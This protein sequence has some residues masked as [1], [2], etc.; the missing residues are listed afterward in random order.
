MRGCCTLF[1]N[2]PIDPIAPE[3][4]DGAQPFKRSHLRLM[5]H[6]RVPRCLRHT[7]VALLLV[8]ANL[9]HA[10]LYGATKETCL[11]LSTRARGRSTL[12]E[13]SKKNRTWGRKFANE[14]VRGGGL[15]FITRT[16]L[17]LGAPGSAVFCKEMSPTLQFQPS[18]VKLSPNILV[19]IKQ[20]CPPTKARNA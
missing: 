12:H 18:G 16:L 7:N 20:V 11:R 4:P 1:I 8:L 15:A 9:D 2:A 6:C 17:Q 10:L 14:E 5:M 19:T 3:I 13:P